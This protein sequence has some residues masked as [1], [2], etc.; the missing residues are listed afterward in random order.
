MK[1]RMMGGL[2]GGMILAL[3][4]VASA[5]GVTV[6]GTIKGD[7]YTHTWTVAPE[8][9]N[10]QPGNAKVYMYQDS[11][12][13]DLYVA[14]VL[15]GDYNDNTYGTPVGKAGAAGTNAGSSKGWGDYGKTH[16][17]DNLVGSDKAT[18][19]F[20]FGATFAKDG[21]PTYTT[22]KFAGAMDYL[23]NVDKNGVILPTGA[24]WGSAGFYGSVLLPT[25]GTADKSEG[26][27]TTG[28]V[29]N[30]LGAESSMGYNFKKYGASNPSWFGASGVSPTSASAPD[31][32]YA[33]I[34]EM[35][36]KG[37]NFGKMV[38]NSDPSKGFI[39][40]FSFTFGTV[41]ASP[42]MNDDERDQY[43]NYT[44]G[45]PDKP[46][47]PVVPLPSSVWMGGLTLAGLIVV[48]RMRRQTE[49]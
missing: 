16:T 37:S 23:A 34:Y 39:N 21:T 9:P 48:R 42:S 29:S 13:F 47:T 41:H 27:V 40:D 45:T 2:A 12:T 35:A 5:A 17:F 44:P 15:P 25:G 33:S 20:G 46:G 38:L 30:V 32:E 11:V 24:N 10:P 26:S 14:F 36:F 1:S 8:G 49:I 18:V 43:I 31:W 22:A 4:G 19:S 28:S 6:D 3:A 7:S